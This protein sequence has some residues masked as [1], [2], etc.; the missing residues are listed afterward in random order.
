MRHLASDI[1][2]RR[3]DEAREKIQKA[4]IKMMF[5]LA[6]LILPALLLVILFPALYN[7]VD[8]LSHTG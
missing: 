1:R 4:P 8:V 7:I 3:R 6:F 2:K 5:P